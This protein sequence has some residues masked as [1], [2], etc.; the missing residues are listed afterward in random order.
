VTGPTLACRQVKF[1]GSSHRTSRGFPI[2]SLQAVLFDMDGLL[3]DTE[4]LWLETETVV[5]SRL[6]SPPWTPQDQKALLGGSLEKTVAYLLSKAS[7][8]QPSQVVADWVM[9]DVE[10]RV[11]AGG[12]AARPGARELHAAL[13]GAE[14]PVG[15]VT[16]SRRRLM[17]AVLETTGFAFDITVCSDDVTATK[18]DPEPY[19]LAVKLLGADPAGCVVL[20][21]SPNGVAS[22]RAAGCPVVAVPSFIPITPAPG[23]TVAG[24]LGD[25]DADR[26]RS[27][28]LE[29]Q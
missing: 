2:Y 6:G 25:L 29:G 17:R 3:V 7:R 18:P 27:L 4:P 28:V 14:I 11:L 24:S 5:A 23:V 15:L 8:P 22:A 10:A 1:E 16:S 13:R 26:L 20:E 19:Q 9:D 21:D 12:A